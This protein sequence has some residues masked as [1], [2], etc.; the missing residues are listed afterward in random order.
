MLLVVG[1]FLEAM[2]W[3]T[4]QKD[5]RAGL[6]IYGNIFFLL[7]RYNVTLDN[8]GLCNNQNALT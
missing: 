3:V 5:I 8:A 7:S 6:K 4:C 2:P 1:R